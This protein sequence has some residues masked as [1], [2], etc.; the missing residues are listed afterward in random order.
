M[1]QPSGGNPIL[2]LIISAKDEAS[3]LFGKVFRSLND[4]TNVIAT[5]IREAFAGVLNITDDAQS[6]EAQMARVQAKSQ[7]SAEDMAKLKQAALDMGLQMGVSAT[8]AA[9]GLEI[10]TGA[11]LTVDQ[12]IAALAPTLRVMATEQ[13]SAAE[14]AAALTDVMALM[15]VSLE[16]AGRA[17]DV[18]QAGADATS[19]SVMAMAEA[20]RGA[21]AAASTAGLTLEET[22]TILTTFAKYGLQGSEAGTALAGML[23]QLNDPASKARVEL[24]K[25]GQ[26]SGDVGEMI[27]T[28]AQAGPRG[29]AAMLAFGDAQSGVNA[30]LK[31][32]V[33]GFAEYG[34]AIAASGGGLEKAANTI[35]KT[36]VGALDRLT[37]SWEQVKLAVTGPL[38]EP[39]A[40]GA[41]ELAT[42][43]GALANSGALEKIGKGI[44]DAFVTGGQQVM[45]FLKAVD[46]DALQTQALTTVATIKTSMDDLISG[47]QGKIQT[48]SDWTTTVFS[49]LT[50]AVDGYRLAWYTARGEQDKAAEAQTRL[51]QTSAAMARAL[52]G[53]SA[54]LQNHTVATTALTTAQQ[55]QT[56]VSAAARAEIATLTAALKD[57]GLSA[58]TAAA[59][60]VRLE[61]AQTALAI[62]Q[63][64]T[65]DA[66]TASIPET[67]KAAA[68]TTGLATATEQAKAA[69]DIYLANWEKGHDGLTKATSAHR[70][71]N[72]GVADVIKTIE[73]GQP[74]MAEWNGALVNSHEGV[75]NLG[76]GLALVIQPLTTVAEKTAEYNRQIKAGIDN[77]G[78]WRS[79]MELNSVT[80]LGLRDTAQA[81]AEKLAY[82]QSI[83]ATLPDA[84]R[85]I[86]IAKQAAT[87]AQNQYN[88]ALD[89]NITQQERLTAGIQRANQIEETRYDLQIQQV[90]AEG[91]LAQAKGDTATATQKENEATDLQIEKL[92]AATQRKQAEI[93]AYQELI[94]AT[95]LKLAADGELDASDKNQLATMAD[96]A[97]A[98]ENE[99]QQLVQIAE[100]TRELADAQKEGAEKATQATKADTEATKEN[101]KA[102]AGR[103][104]GV[105]DLVK[106]LDGVTEK[107]LE[108]AKAMDAGTRSSIGGVQGMM[109]YAMAVQ[110]AVGYIKSTITA[111]EELN[112]KI[113]ELNETV[114]GTGPAAARAQQ[115][116]LYMARNGGA[117]IRGLSQAGEE[118]RQKLVEIKNAALDAE[119]ALAE[120]AQDFTKQILQLQGDQKALLDLEQKERLQQLDDLYTKAGQLGTAEYQAAKARADELHQ[121]KLQ[122]LADEEAASQAQSAT[123]KTTSDLNALADATGRV[124]SGFK[125]MSEVDLSRV[126]GQAGQLTN[127]FN[128]LNGIL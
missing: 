125:S 66:V 71:L 39:I 72:G 11:G 73:A 78:D 108:I 112:A 77:A 10:L 124:A 41:Q 58:E 93:Q 117:E 18:L 65:T 76:D 100:Q 116:L 103:A 15:G 109:Q 8:D 22:A 62:A 3:A 19:T 12:A 85:Q 60:T 42:Q 52:S 96:T 82:L 57:S 95:Q 35:G 9:Q 37:A 14:A 84:D 118:A 21:G 86:A 121:L 107:A 23:Y 43:L 119:T 26:T 54:E 80:M 115:E 61:A 97:E 6:F 113:D 24:A 50:A 7:A 79:G 114:D 25:L 34:A 123:Q 16:Q 40:K 64:K 122:Q 92:Q 59:Y 4:S 56:D 5:N 126:T 44:A 104:A 102:T 17:G 2:Q 31:A 28:L 33:T 88:T 94:A 91:Q 69:T 89:E 55:Q 45:D 36:T 127:Y 70:E 101:T 63:G 90:Q 13:V 47:V 1:A 20:M 81:T 128:E 38:L 67:Q 27:D 87:Q 75:T 120:M 68:A 48:V 32:G 111:E 49:P 46:W 106:N 29:G 105:L 99:R 98:M 51:E 83:Q 74:G 110:E 30:L 53:T